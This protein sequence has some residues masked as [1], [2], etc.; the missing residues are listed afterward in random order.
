MFARMLG[1]AIGGRKIQ[2]MILSGELGA[3]HK[4]PSQRD[5]SQSLGISRAS[6]REALLTLETLGMLVT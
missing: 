3:G 4:I 6:L 1:T 5:L 2:G